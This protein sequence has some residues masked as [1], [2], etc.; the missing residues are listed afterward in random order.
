MDWVSDWLAMAYSYL[1]TDKAPNGKGLSYKIIYSLLAD[2]TEL[3]EA[4]PYIMVVS[5]TIIVRV[6][7]DHCSS[8]LGSWVT[9]MG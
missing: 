3:W 5:V 8:V 2:R 7:V 9:S 4:R 1:C 6:L